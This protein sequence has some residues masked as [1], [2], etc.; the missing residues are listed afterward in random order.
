MSKSYSIPETEPGPNPSVVVIKAQ[1]KATANNTWHPSLTGCVFWS[2]F[3]NAWRF[4]P[5]E[6][7]MQNSWPLGSGW[8]LCSPQKNESFSFPWTILKPTS[9]LEH[10]KG[11]LKVQENSPLWLH[12]LFLLLPSRQSP[13]FATTIASTARALRSSPF[14]WLAAFRY[15]RGRTR[16]KELMIMV[17]IRR[18]CHVHQIAE[19]LGLQ[20]VIPRPAMDLDLMS[21]PF[22]N[23]WLRRPWHPTAWGTE[24]QYI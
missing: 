19:E 3:A 4:D 7:S 9:R 20:M 10:R 14:W 13:S 11:W 12:S 15:Q 8:L 1:R 17:F 16:S 5:I 18:S 24:M 2:P 6:A 22:S 23:L 21:L